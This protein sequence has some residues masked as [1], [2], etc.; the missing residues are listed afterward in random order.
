MQFCFYYVDDNLK[1]E[2]EYNNKIYTYI[3]DT[4]GNLHLISQLYDEYKVIG[5]YGNSDD[6]KLYLDIIRKTLGDFKCKFIYIQTRTNELE[7]KNNIYNIKELNNIYMDAIIIGS[8][9][10]E[11]QIKDQIKKYARLSIT[12]YSLKNDLG[13]YKL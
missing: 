7:K 4:I 13:Y 9:F 3:R 8:V 6:C 12:I 11:D 1:K 5:I 2:E 10:F